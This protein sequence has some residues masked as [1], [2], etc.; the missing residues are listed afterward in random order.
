MADSPSHSGPKSN[1]PNHADGSASAHPALSD[2]YRKPGPAEIAYFRGT[3]RLEQALRE[4]DYEGAARQVRKNLT[5]IR[6]WLREDRQ[7]ERYI[8][9]IRS[10]PTLELGG[11]ALAIVGDAAGIS[12]LR[13]L[14]AS[15]PELAPWAEQVE[16]H[17][18]SCRLV[19]EI[20]NLVRAHPGVLQREMKRR[21]GAEDGRLVVRLIEYLERAGRITRVRV[22][23]TWQLFPPGSA[24]PE[25]S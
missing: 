4:R 2:L 16:T 21:L 3:E 6:R 9:V 11:I 8:T 14:V 19:P 1:G 25:G 23:R 20:E 5:L 7:D 15:E 12:R 24:P 18:L 22:H 17:D 10:V 13:R